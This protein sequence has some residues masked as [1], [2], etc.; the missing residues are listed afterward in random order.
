MDFSPNPPHLTL[1]HV[2]EQ[3]QRSAGLHDREQ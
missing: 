3:E 1:L 2:A